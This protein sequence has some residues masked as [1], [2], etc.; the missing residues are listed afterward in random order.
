MTTAAAMKQAQ[1]LSALRRT[2]VASSSNASTADE[3]R[4]GRRIANGLR[5]ATAL[6]TLAIMILVLFAVVD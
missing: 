4:R 2:M 6:V 5:G 3:L 1:S